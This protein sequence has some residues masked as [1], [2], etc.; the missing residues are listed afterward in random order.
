MLVDDEKRVENYQGRLEPFFLSELVTMFD[1][2]IDGE[3]VMAAPFGL[4]AR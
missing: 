4:D 1:P 3:M 2:S